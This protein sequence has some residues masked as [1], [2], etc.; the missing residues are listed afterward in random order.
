MR[1]TLTLAI[2]LVL[3][4]ACV[5]MVSAANLVLNGD[6]ES[7]LIGGSYVTCPGGTCPVGAIT[8]WTAGNNVN[9]IRGY[10][11]S[12]GGSAQSIDLSGEGARGSLSQPIP[13]ATAGTYALT[14]DISG[15]FDC[16]PDPK[17]VQIWWD[18]SIVGTQIFPKPV[19]WSVSNMQW[20]SMTKQ[21][22]DPV[23][24]STEL[25]FVDVSADVTNCGVALDNIVVVADENGGVPVPEFPTV[26]LPAAL[27]VG[28]LGAVLFIRNTKEE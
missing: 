18:G 3:L 28:L 8:S 4:V 19:G 16:G 21:L 7:P 2:T 25:K 24:I 23:G 5:G 14:Y 10:W 26:A 11:I 12:A 20:T 15:N 13:T 6:F 17:E 1:K 22:P 9:L 27:I